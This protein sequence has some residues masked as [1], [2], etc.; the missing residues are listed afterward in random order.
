MYS[1]FLPS[2]TPLF[3]ANNCDRYQRQEWIK[4]IEELTGRK[5]LIYIANHNHP[6]SSITRDDLLPFYDILYD[7]RPDCQDDVDLIVH[8]PGGDPN[9]AELIV[10]SILSKA[11]SFRVIVPLMAKSAATM[12]CLAA[13]EIVMSDS[14][15]LGPID[16]QIPIRQPSGI[17]EYRPAIAFL[18][19]IEKI[20]EEAEQ[21]GL[22]PVYIPILQ[23]IDPA[24][25]TSCEQAINFT[26]DLGEKWLL[27]SMC[28]DNP[29]KAA[30][31][32][33][34]LLDIDKYPNH[35]QVI[36]YEEA[37]QIGLK[38]EYI[39]F[40]SDLWQLIWRLTVIYQN[41]LRTKQLVKIFESRNYSAVI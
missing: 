10:N 37:R 39:K 6:L 21:K 3:Y 41:E 31:I 1:E 20:K 15:E 28:K 38:V 18:K 11:K 24:F 22:N 7:I 19:G 12:M 34:Q 32:V 27:R 4:K 26:R 35:G 29:K 36:N 13:D 25:L 33:S 23:G 40:D 16:P 14:S 9:A 17:V 8:S 5:V 30:E 2:Q